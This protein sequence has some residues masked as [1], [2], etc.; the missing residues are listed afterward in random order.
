MNDET[1]NFVE[2]YRDLLQ[3]QGELGANDLSRQRDFALQT[4]EQERRNQFQ[5]IMGAANAA[6]MM[7][8]NFPERAKYQ[9]DTGTYNPAAAQV[10]TSYKTGLDRLRA[11]TL[12]A[13]NTLAE[14]SDEIA[15][16]NKQYQ[17][18]NMPT[19][20]V[21]LNE[22]GDYIVNSLVDG[23]Q[24]YNASG[25]KIRLGTAL[26]RAGITSNEDILRGA[27][28]VLSEEEAKRLKTIFDR[29]ANTKHPNFIYNV[30][31]SYFEPNY[32]YLSPEDNAF[33]GR[34]GLGFGS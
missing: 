31:E 22:A 19:G 25:D 33:I 5:N 8:S 7:Y 18:S 17:K 29:Q 9:Y 23:S 1:N 26:K 24:F 21:K 30:G 14:Y 34:L 15:S 11:N 32:S 13:L 27:E 10:Q 3:T 2:A 12:N 16:L 4:L 6:G 28:Q 20:A